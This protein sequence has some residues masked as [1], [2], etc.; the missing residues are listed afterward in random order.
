MEISDLKCEI[1]GNPAV[2][3]YRLVRVDLKME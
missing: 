1:C 3:A 2:M